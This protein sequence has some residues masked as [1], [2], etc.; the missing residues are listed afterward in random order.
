MSPE[1]VGKIQLD[2]FKKP[3]FVVSQNPFKITMYTI[4]I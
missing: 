2:A 4:K 3:D 1:E